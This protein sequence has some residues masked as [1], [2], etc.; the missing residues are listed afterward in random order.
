[1]ALITEYATIWMSQPPETRLTPDAAIDLVTD[2][3][4]TGITGPTF[5][6][7]PRPSQNENPFG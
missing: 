3:I 1:M 5:W 2:L 6:P 4:R 7:T